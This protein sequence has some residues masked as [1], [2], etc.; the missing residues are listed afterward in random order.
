MADVT[1][2]LIEH[3]SFENARAKGYEGLFAQGSGYLHV[4][5]SFEEGLVSAPQNVTYLRRPTNV[6]AE[7]F[8]EMKSKWGT[9]VPGI[10]GVH[11]LMGKELANLPYFLDLTPTVDGERL[12]MECCRVEDYQRALSFQT[13]TLTRAFRWLTQSG[14]VVSVRFERFVN[15]ARPHLCVQRLTLTSD[16]DVHLDLRA[17]ID[18]DVRTSGY[19]H[20]SRVT[21]AHE[22]ADSV[23][24]D[25][26]L[27]SG[28]WISSA[29][30]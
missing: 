2:H 29:T 19:D 5:G 12:D 1:T 13:A 6:T 8:P 17:G 10:Y 11:P 14:A 30:A 21:F 24:C 16:R 3:G 7:K 20:F 23:Q 28:D 27:D 22:S 25:V 18:S 4:R 26:T 15:A 9:F